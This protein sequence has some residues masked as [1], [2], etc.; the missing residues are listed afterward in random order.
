[1]FGSAL[2]SIAFISIR[3]NICIYIYLC[4]S[5]VMRLEFVP[6]KAQRLAIFAGRL[7]A[8]GTTEP[9]SS[10]NCRHCP[11]A[12]VL[13]SNKH[14]LMVW[15]RFVSEMVLSQK[16]AQSIRR[17]MTCTKTQL[18][19]LVNFLNAH[20]NKRKHDSRSSFNTT[21]CPVSKI[22]YVTFLRLLISVP[23]SHMAMIQ[24]GLL[25]AM[26]AT[27]STQ[28]LRDVYGLTK[29]DMPWVLVELVIHAMIARRAM[30]FE[31]P[32][33]LRCV[34]FFAG[35][36]KSSQ[37]AKA[38]T[39]LGFPAL[40]FDLLRHLAVKKKSKVQRPNH[41]QSCLMCHNMCCNIDK[42]YC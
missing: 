29:L 25:H 38:F 2:S 8:S 31:V 17:Q 24:V 9:S 5:V 12:L 16:H 30:D 3:I 11:L 7:A 18:M 13:A 36:D 39:E 32:Q 28:E 10:S 1:M 21:K 4:M 41:K 6:P 19:H 22:K 20:W 40:A 35:T 14:E 33:D 23:H 37:I 42:N 26:L 34:E 27:L 15:K